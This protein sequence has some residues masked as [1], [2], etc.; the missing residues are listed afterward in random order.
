MTTT[1]YLK[2]RPKQYYRLRMITIR[3]LYLSNISGS[4]DKNSLAVFEKI[5]RITVPKKDVTNCHLGFFP[6][7]LA[8]QGVCGCACALVCMQFLCFLGFL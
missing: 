6:G 8:F 2:R 5:S 1:S 4:V 3:V 7:L